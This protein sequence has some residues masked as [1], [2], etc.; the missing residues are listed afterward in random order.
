MLLNRITRMKKIITNTVGIIILLSLAFAS[1]MSSLTAVNP[2]TKASS[3]TESR[4]FLNSI[5]V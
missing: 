3:L 2:P 1:A 4:F 5:T